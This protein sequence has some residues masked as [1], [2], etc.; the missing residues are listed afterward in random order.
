MDI[1]N[2]GLTIILQ[3]SKVHRI[4]LI[5]DRGGELFVE[6]MG[7]R[8]DDE[9]KIDPAINRRLSD[10]GQDLPS[11]PLT[12]ISPIYHLAKQNL[13]LNNMPNAVHSTHLISYQ[14]NS[15][16]CIPLLM[17]QAQ[18]VGILY[19][20]HPH[21]NFFTQ[22]ILTL[23]S[24]LADQLRISLENAQKYES[25][26]HKITAHT[27]MEEALRDSEQKYRTLFRISQRQ[28]QESQLL[29]QV[30][31]AL[32][33]ELELSVLIKI[34]VEAVAS[35]FGY[36]QV[37]LYLLQ[38]ETLHL[39]HQIGYHQVIAEIPINRGIAG[40]VVRQG[41]PIF[42]EDVQTD[43]EFLGAIE[44]IT[45]E[46]CVP[47]FDR[48]QVVG[49]FNVE[50]TR[51]IRLTEADLQLITSLSV[52]INLA[53]GRARLY[54]QVRENEERFSK[55]FHTNLLAI[56]ISRL[57]DGHYI[58]V[59][60]RYL[61]IFGYR[62]DEVLGS[63]AI[64][65]D[66]WEQFEERDRVIKILRKQRA[67]R[68]METRFRT[69]SGTLRDG[70]ISCEV[71]ELSGESFILGMFQDITDRKRVEQ[72]LRDSEERH[73][74]LVENAPFCIHEMDQDGYIQTM[75]QAGLQML[76]VDK[77]NK[78]VGRSC[79][80]FMAEK[81]HPK[82]QQ[83]MRDTFAG[84][85]AEFE[86]SYEHQGK[87][88]TFL[89]NFI[90]IRNRNGTVIRIMGITQ[91]ISAR[92]RAEE[93][94]RAYARELERSNQ[95]L[96]TFAS[97]SSHDLQEPLRKIQ[98][99]GDRLQTKYQAQ[100][101]EQGLDYLARIQNAA[102][103]MQTL[104]QDLLAYSR[105]TSEAQP[106]VS[107]DL[108]L[109]VKEVLTD[110]ELRIE[111]VQGE[112]TYDPLPTIE[113]DPTQMRQLF[114]NLISNALKFHKAGLPPQVTIKCQ[115]H[116]ELKEVEIQ[117][118]DNGIGIAPAK[119]ERIFGMFQRLHGRQ[120]YEGSGIGLAI[121]RKIIDRH[122]GSIQVE[123]EINKGSIFVIKLPTQHAPAKLST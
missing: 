59:N 96:Q 85:P 24:H 33:Q 90:P 70:L 113:A 64:K 97:I 114:Q 44:G 23:I 21:P 55:A 20:E 61:E 117:I 68:Q 28:T 60:D 54:T 51:D 71:I 39:Q 72:A 105:I 94:Q 9:L 80:E 31:T 92:K 93:T 46:I 36:T 41:E 45:S 87:H 62:R 103:R 53:I 104:I 8:R 86:Y 108:N 100:L 111:Q 122:Q 12:D 52:H 30:R 67:L 95:E 101:D 50:S 42:L 13:S 16:L 65:L 1:F 75:N 19:L 120:Q 118:C 69:K 123:S 4:V 6:A 58:D 102:A 34:V 56:T 32:A 119:N 109:I 25:L 11:F 76:G 88:R 91:D 83:L 63:S 2:T 106:F 26:Q 17:P 99:F 74:L 14:A 73:R 121:C 38:D 40:R 84:Q 22:D 43:P 115:K 37:S 81:D 10:F 79:L 107:T 35:A 112:I 49:I 66:I 48:N 89:S 27:H 3:H 18:Q 78:V 98:S 7:I 77:L 82:I 5:L 116:K 57:E 110:L 15:I 29:D 47:L